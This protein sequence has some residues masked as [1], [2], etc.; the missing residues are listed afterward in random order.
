MSVIN[1]MLKDLEQRRGDSVTQSPLSGL[2]PSSDVLKSNQQMNV[3]LLAAVLV[4]TVTTVF[5]FVSQHNKWP[6]AT[7]TATPISTPTKAPTKTSKNV[8][9][10]EITQPESKI[11]TVLV[12]N[13]N[14]SLISKKTDTHQVVA[15]SSGTVKSI[16][17]TLI[18]SKATEEK[19]ISINT[20]NA[21][22]SMKLEAVTSNL[23][24]RLVKN[25]VTQVI[26]TILPAVIEKHMRPLTVAQKAQNHFQTA[27]LKLGLGEKNVARRLLEE[28]LSL[29]FSHLRARETL[30]VL[31]L[32]SG[33]ISEAS[34]TVRDGL[35]IN[36]KAAGLAKLYAKILL[37]QDDVELS[38]SILEQ[39]IPPLI[40]DPEY[41]ALLAALY[42]R[43]GKH[44]Q[45]AQTYQQ[46]LQIRPGVSKWWMGL[47]LSSESIGES[48]QALFAYQRAQ[49]VGGLTMEL[50]EFVAQRVQ[51][52]TSI[53][54]AQVTSADI[55]EE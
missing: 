16:E 17:E 38:I 43:A 32:N 39:A 37:G 35:R 55:F 15:P 22:N 14:E 54:S 52:L 40:N 27:I 24:A 10:K 45:A 33:R 23:K 19:P 2:S 50:N 12:T 5:L 51:A 9:Q 47:G 28:T 1:Q 30:A 49:R 21:K 44:G 42:S 7:F 53:V 18:G 46:V 48:T 6:L 26:D 34:A 25:N 31:L 36:P 11:V 13:I 8:A 20:T 41:Y 29:D 4:L 3:L